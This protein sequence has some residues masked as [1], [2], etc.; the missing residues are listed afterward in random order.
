MDLTASSCKVIVFGGLAKTGTTLPLTLLDGNS[1]LTVFPEELRF[2]H[3]GLDSRDANQAANVF[4]KSRHCQLLSE[5]P[6]FFTDDDYMAHGGTGFGRRDYSAFDFKNFAEC[7]HKGFKEAKTSEHRFNTIINAFKLSSGED[8][9]QFERPFVCK[10]PH[11]ET[12]S[13]KWVAM[14]RDRGRYI[15]TTRIPTEHFVSLNNIQKLKRDNERDARKYV[16]TILK[17]ERM[18]RNFP[19]EQ[20]LLLDYDRLIGSTEQAVGELCEFIGVKKEPINDYPTKMNVEWAGNSSRGIVKSEVFENPHVAKKELSK[21]TIIFIEQNLSPLYRRFGWPLLY[22]AR[23]VEN[24]WAQALFSSGKVTWRISEIIT[25]GL[26]SCTTPKMQ[27]ALKRLF[28]K[29]R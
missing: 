5:S 6:T 27:T 11:N 17:R 2:F 13:K 26:R 19:Q 3:V 4:L 21:S 12:H 8:P 10:A 15:I 23:M 25:K 16:D 1:N 28:K 7:I 24:A 22:D 18:W 9:S 20:S 14:L 29:A